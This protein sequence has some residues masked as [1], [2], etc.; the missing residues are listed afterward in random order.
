MT[1]LQTADIVIVGGGLTAQIMSRA[2]AYSGYEI[3]CV[4]RPAYA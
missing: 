1:E 2:L 4:T 3:T